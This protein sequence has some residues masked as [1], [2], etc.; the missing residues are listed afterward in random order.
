MRGRRNRN[1]RR[2]KEVPGNAH[3]DHSDDI[4]TENEDNVNPARHG[5]GN[6]ACPKSLELLPSLTTDLRMLTHDRTSV[7]TLRWCDGIP[8][9]H[10][11]TRLLAPED[12][13]DHSGTPQIH[14]HESPTSGVECFCTQSCRGLTDDPSEV[15]F[16][17]DSWEIDSGDDPVD[18]HMIDQLLH[19]QHVDNSDDDT[20]EHGLRRFGNVVS[21]LPLAPVGLALTPSEAS[22]KC[23]KGALGNGRGYDDSCDPYGS[24]GDLDSHEGRRAD[25]NLRGPRYE[26]DDPRTP[27]GR[28]RLRS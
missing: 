23:V 17:D 3:H 11:L 8:S 22:L 1:R 5:P 6:E 10:Q 4:G 24:A 18:R 9:H 14:R 21:T 28:G 2:K 12:P 13:V 25:P 16:I 27:V 15:D 20:I 19:V 26:I 7:R